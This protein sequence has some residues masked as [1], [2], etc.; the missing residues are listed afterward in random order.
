MDV[1]TYDDF[2]AL[3]AMKYMALLKMQADIGKNHL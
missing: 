1:G 3:P 2:V